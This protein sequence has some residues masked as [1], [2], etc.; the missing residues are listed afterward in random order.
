MNYLV[1]W[2]PIVVGTPLPWWNWLMAT[3]YHRTEQELEEEMQLVVLA[4]ENPHHFAPLYN[5]YYE[6]IYGFVYKRIA[7]YDTSADITGKVF[8]LCLENLHRYQ[9]RGLPFSAW[10]YRIALNEITGY[11]RKHTKAPRSVQLE[12]KHLHALMHELKVEEG[13]SPEA[14]LEKLLEDLSEQEIQMLE[15][16]FFEDRSFQE[17]GQLL[18]IT[19]NNAKVKT[20][21]ILDKLKRV[22]ATLRI[23]WE[24]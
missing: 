4:Q 6:P 1:G 2:L 7:D 18:S 3:S 14:L 21:R 16:R 15:L 24:K 20:Y 11:F 9:Y 17:I 23:K 19:E 13:T 5:R 10:L 12:D 8:C 22:A